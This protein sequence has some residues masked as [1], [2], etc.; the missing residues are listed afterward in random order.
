MSTFFTTLSEQTRNE[1]LN[2]TNHPFIGAAMRGDIDRESYVAF[3]QQAYYHVR[4]TAPLMMAAGARFSGSKAPLRAA[5]AEYIEE[6]I[7]HAGR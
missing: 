2:L 1:Q 7:G 5:M 3:L 6:E 4:E